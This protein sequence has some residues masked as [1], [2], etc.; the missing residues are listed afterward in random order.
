MATDA[1]SVSR[2][3]IDLPRQCGKTL[4]RQLQAATHPRVDRPPTPPFS[5]GARPAPL[6]QPCGIACEP[7]AHDAE[8]WRSTFGGA[9]AEPLTSPETKGR[10][11]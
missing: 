8:K 4:A 3:F 6:P 10:G 7:K 11:A 1:K 2:S 9:G 5:R